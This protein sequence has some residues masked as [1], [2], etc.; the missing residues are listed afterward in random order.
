M[1]R[2]EQLKTEI[3]KVENQILMAHMADVL[4]WDHYYKLNP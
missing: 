3:D 2:L 1:T 4:D